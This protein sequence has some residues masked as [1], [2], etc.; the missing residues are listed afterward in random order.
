MQLL[1]SGRSAEQILD[2]LYLNTLSRFPNDAERQQLLS[3]L[4]DVD[5]TESA[6][7]L[8]WAILNS[9]EFTFNH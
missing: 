8:M 7:D 2:E 9:K 3:G 4:Q 6:V 1:G 5:R